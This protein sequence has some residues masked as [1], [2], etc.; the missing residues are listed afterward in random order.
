MC[1]L[2]Q[3]S[4]LARCSPPPSPFINSCWEHSLALKAEKGSKACHQ[5][6]FRKGR[7]SW[8]DGCS[9]HHC[10][11]WGSCSSLGSIGLRAV[12]S[13][14]LGCQEH[15][16]P[17]WVLTQCGTNTKTFAILQEFVFYV[18]DPSPAKMWILPLLD[19]FIQSNDRLKS[20]LQ[21]KTNSLYV[22]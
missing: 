20:M 14:T 4:S 3:K 19:T 16:N 6:P 2:P 10:P 17:V 21:V 13:R 11:A 5:L 18:F 9:L 8:E 7:I 1:L 12:L 22:V 15:L